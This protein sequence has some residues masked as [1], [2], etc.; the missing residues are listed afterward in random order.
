MV[1]AVRPAV[2]EVP[3]ERL[4]AAFISQRIAKGERDARMLFV[5]VGLSPFR[6]REFILIWSRGVFM[7]VTRVFSTF[8]LAMSV[9]SFAARIQAADTSPLTELDPEIAN[10][11]GKMIHDQFAKENKDLQC[12]LEPNFEK[13]TGLFNAETNEGIIAVPAKT[14][15]ED[16]ENKELEKDPGAPV[17]FLC[18]SQTYNPLIDGKAIDAKKLRKIKFD[19][20]QGGAAREATCLLCTV[21][22]LEGDDY[23]LYVY[24]TDKAPL[25]KSTFGEANNAPKADLA[26]TIEDPKKDSATLVFNIFGKYSASIPIAHKMDVKETKET[27]PKVKQS[28]SDTK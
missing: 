24:G 16:R 28:T 18:M 9:L 15:K 26:L 22:H 8:V 2:A 21:R 6:R 7:A 27:K 14:F 3:S 17:C 4:N 12:K 19:D 1:S 5:L 10:R 13:A 11:F 23:E 25:L 20:G